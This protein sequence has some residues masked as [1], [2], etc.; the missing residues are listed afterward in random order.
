MAH[1]NFSKAFESVSH[2]ILGDQM[3]TCGLVV[4]PLGGFQVC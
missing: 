4:A 2:E 1:L 3:V